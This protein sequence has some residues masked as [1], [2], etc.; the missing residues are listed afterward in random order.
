MPTD[1]ALTSNTEVYGRNVTQISQVCGRNVTHVPHAGWITD[2]IPTA[3][4][5]E[6]QAGR[7]HHPSNPDLSTL[8]WIAVHRVALDPMVPTAIDSREAE[9]I[10]P[11]VRNMLHSVEALRFLLARVA[12]P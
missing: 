8:S 7:S 2:L 10:S 1:T 12:F 5:T 6:C 11:V 3:V 4:F 9:A